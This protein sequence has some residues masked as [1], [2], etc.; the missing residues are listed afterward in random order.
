LP[1]VVASIT[2]YAPVA[3]LE[4]NAASRGRSPALLDSGRVISFQELESSVKAVASQLV[5]EGVG[6]GDV[7]GV[8]LPNVWQY[9]VLELAVPYVGGIILPLPL[10]L[11]EAE[12]EHALS[13]SNAALAIGGAGGGEALAGVASK[14]ET[15]VLDA[16]EL[17]QRS[18]AGTAVQ[19][20]PPDPERVVEI[21][22]TSGTTGLPKLAS[23]TASLKQVTFEAFTSRLE[24]TE[25]D[26]VLIVSPVTQGI[27]GMCLYCLRLGAGLVMLRRSRFDPAHVLATAEST[28]STLMVGV[29]TNI[30]RLLACDEFNG[31]ELS[32]VRATAVAG[33][34]MPADVARRWEESTGSRVCIFYGSMDAGQLAVASPSDPPEKRWHTVGRP[35]DCAELLI[36]DPDGEPVPPGEVGEICMRGP[37]VQDRYWGEEKGPYSEDGW[38][39]MGDLGF[40]DEDGYL[41]VVGRL[42]DII[43]RG[44]TNINPH[45]VEAVL[46][47]DARISEICIVGRPDHDLGERAV[48]F[49]VPVAGAELQLDDLRQH[50]QERGVARYKWPEFLEVVDELPL[51]GPGKV[52]RRQLRE[53]FAG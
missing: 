25:D 48:A 28:R 31:A 11:G 16:E 41:H 44:G 49:V 24:V 47:G 26:K 4:A 2:R 52:N 21:A 45:E 50:L 13:A 29:P 42:K 46:R 30:T 32:S 14:R 20:P 36:C 34:P 19:P 12:L 39:H 9:V 37:T 43:I 17:C 40:L 53:R 18:H 3:Y 23:L 7:V 38:A 22:L 1:A 5:A 33:A 27:G 15:R 10:T 6:A 8:Q 51:S 35:H